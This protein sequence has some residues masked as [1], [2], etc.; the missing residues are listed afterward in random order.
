MTVEALHFCH[1]YCIFPEPNWVWI[2]TGISRNKDNDSSGVKFISRRVLT[3]PEDITTNYN[4]IRLLADDLNTTYRI[5]LSLNARD[6]IKATFGFQKKLID[7]GYDL[8]R[9]LPDAIAQSKKLGSIW[10]TELAQRSSRATKR[11][12]LDIDDAS[13]LQSSS[14][15]RFLEDRGVE[16]IVYRST[17]SGVHIVFEACD[18]RELMEFVRNSGFK[19]DPQRDSMIFVEQWKP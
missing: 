8:A 13:M 19:V 15:V 14:I 11:L 3:T 5:Y 2:M 17:V 16:I 1:Q 18:T 7:I 4:D 9:G 10:K 12:L 6:V